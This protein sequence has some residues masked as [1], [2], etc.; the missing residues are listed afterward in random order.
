M[1]MANLTLAVDNWLFRPLTATKYGHRLTKEGKR[2]KK[3]CE[4][5]REVLCRLEGHQLSQMLVTKIDCLKAW[6][7][8]GGPRTPKMA[9][10]KT[11]MKAD[12]QCP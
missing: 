2:Y 5:V 4:V 7:R 10:L 8:A 1:A 11:P 9:M 3:V 6:L 12:S